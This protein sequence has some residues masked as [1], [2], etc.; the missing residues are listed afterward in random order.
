MQLRWK[1]CWKTFQRGCIAS[2]YGKSAPTRSTDQASYKSRKTS[3]FDD[4][5]RSQSA[6]PALRLAAQF[7]IPCNVRSST[8]LPPKQSPEC[9]S[10][11]AKTS[12]SSHQQV[13]SKLRTWRPCCI[14]TRTASVSSSTASPLSGVSKKP[15]PMQ[16]SSLPTSRSHRR[17][18][19]VLAGAAAVYHIGPTFHTFETQIG[20]NM[21]TAALAHQKADGIFKH[22]V[23][24]S[25]T[26]TQIRK[27]LNHDAKRLVEEFLVESGLPYTIVKPTHFM[28]M[29][30]VAEL[31][32]SA[33]QDIT[34]PAWWDPDTKFAFIALRDLGFAASKFLIEREPHFFAAYDLCGTGL[35]SHTEQCEIAGKVIG[36]TITPVLT[37]FRKAVDDFVAGKYGKDVPS[38]SRDAAERLFLYYNRHGLPGNPSL[39][40]WILGREP[41][42]FRKWADDQVKGAKEKGD[43]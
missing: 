9:H 16:K 40:R 26:H 13:A 11:L 17:R 3:I 30:P 42:S 14:N 28:D 10:T 24:S 34:W 25:V 33:E 15:F 43:V 22:F 29:F 8:L 20:H 21:V 6:G 27:L 23:Y 1:T 39:L 36:K 32:K 41:T 7:V 38:Y 19:K 31:M 2:T 35:M 4:R 5:N 18:S 37:D 12:L